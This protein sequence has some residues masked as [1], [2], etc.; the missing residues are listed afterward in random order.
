MVV[1]SKSRMLAGQ[2][3]E[4]VGATAAARQRWGG[5]TWPL[6]G[7]QR[8]ALVV[9]ACVTPAATTILV[10]VH[11]AAQA[12]TQGVAVAVVACQHGRD[13]RCSSSS[14]TTTHSSHAAVMVRVRAS[15]SKTCDAASEAGA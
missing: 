15:T 3:E 13:S 8:E 5:Q 7:F 11:P 2:E 1:G 6:R 12:A 4:V 10:A 9:V 14:T